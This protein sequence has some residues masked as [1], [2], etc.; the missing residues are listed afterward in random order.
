M[1]ATAGYIAG[2]LFFVAG[3]YLM[4]QGHGGMEIRVMSMG[5]GI[6]SIGKGVYAIGDLAMK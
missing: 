4:T 6:Y 5:V 2:A 1:R 3:L